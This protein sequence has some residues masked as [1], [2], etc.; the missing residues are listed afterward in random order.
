MNYIE[1]PQ[2]I[3]SVDSVA[4]ISCFGHL[5]TNHSF[6]CHLTLRYHLHNPTGDSKE[7]DNKYLTCNLLFH[8]SVEIVKLVFIITRQVCSDMSPH[9]PGRI[10]ENKHCI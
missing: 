8:C 1:A 2:G 4:L 7:I 9:P 5:T 10:Q 6:H 3:N